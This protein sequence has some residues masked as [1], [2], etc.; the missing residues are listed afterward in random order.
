M[1][2]GDVIHY[3]D[4]LNDDFAG[5]GI[6]AV[7]VGAVFPFCP[8]KLIWRTGEFFA[9]YFVAIPLVALCWLFSG[10]TIH[11]KKNIRRLRK[12]QRSRGGKGYF[13]YANHTHWLDAFAGPLVCFPKKSHVLVSPD[14]VSIKGIRTFVQMLGAI[15]VPT[16]R[17][18]VPLFVEAIEKRIDSGRA[19]MIFPEAHIWPYCTFIRNFKSGSFRYPVKQDVPAVAVCTTYTRHR[20]LLKWM[21]TAKRHVYISEP[22]YPDRSLSAPLAK[23]KLRDEVYEWL[24]ET[25]AAHSDYEYVRY[26]KEE[27]E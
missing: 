5:N 15:P 25:A 22:F 7:K 16:E 24:K 12:E 20:G 13:L 23:Q 11:G 9:Y 4:E 27:K 21:K 26:E 17:E 6:S 2:R 8:Q 10:Y 1:K 3:R 18:A 14:T 19:V